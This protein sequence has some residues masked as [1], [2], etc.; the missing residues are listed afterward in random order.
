MTDMLME[1]LKYAQ[2]P[3]CQDL[4]KTQETKKMHC[5]IVHFC[6]GTNFS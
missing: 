1:G 2:H 3:L 6:S 4:K 5:C